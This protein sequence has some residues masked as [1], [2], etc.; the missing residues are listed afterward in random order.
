MGMVLA[1]VLGGLGLWL[2]LWALDGFI[3]GGLLGLLI[4][5]GVAIVASIGGITE[6]LRS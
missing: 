2:G 5:A 1:V 3:W 4:G 6:W